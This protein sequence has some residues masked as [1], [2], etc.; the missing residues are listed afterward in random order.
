MG[1][2]ARAIA[3]FAGGAIGQAGPQRL[4]R[5]RP[6]AGPARGWGGWLGDPRSAVLLVLASVLLL[7]GW[8]FP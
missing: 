8:P 6:G 2:W 3:L 5:P 4:P 1:I 7:G